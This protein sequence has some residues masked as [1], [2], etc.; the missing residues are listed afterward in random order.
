MKLH[1][2]IHM[3]VVYEIYK[4]QT[5]FCLES[6]LVSRVIRVVYILDFMLH[7][8]K[9]NSCISLQLHEQTLSLIHEFGVEWTCVSTLVVV[10][11]CWRSFSLTLCFHLIIL[12]IIESFIELLVPYISWQESCLRLLIR[13]GLIWCLWIASHGY[14]LVK[15]RKYEFLDPFFMAARKGSIPPLW[16]IDPLLFRVVS[17]LPARKGSIPPPW[18]IDPPVQ[19]QP[20]AFFDNG[21]NVFYTTRIRAPFVALEPRLKGI[22]FDIKFDHSFKKTILPLGQRSTSQCQKGNL[23]ARF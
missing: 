8:L 21:H 11:R 12:W 22:S 10:H 1:V 13:F 18:R 2:L 19:T 20:V 16:W 7:V 23:N 3:N 9:D 17:R 4:S 15:L 14:A 5:R 6:A